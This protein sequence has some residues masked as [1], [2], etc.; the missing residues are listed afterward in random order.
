MFNSINSLDFKTIP[1]G[2]F[3]IPTAPQK[4]KTIEFFDD[5]YTYPP[6]FRVKWD[7]IDELHEDLFMSYNYRILNKNFPFFKKTCFAE[8]EAVKGNKNQY[9]LGSYLDGY[10]AKITSTRFYSQKSKGLQAA[11]QAVPVYTILNG[12]GEIVLANSTDKL[13]SQSPDLQSSLYQFCGSFDPIIERDMQLGLFFLSRNDAEVYLQEIAKM[14][15]QGTKMLGLSIHCFG[16][17]FAYRV[18]REYHPQIDFR[19]IPNLQSVQSFLKPA[20][21]SNSNLIFDESQQQLRFR[22]RPRTVL[23]VFKQLN[24]WF[25]PISSFLAKSEYFKGVPIFV[26]QVNDNSTNFLT[27]QGSRMVN[28]V[29]TV[30]AWALKPLT[31]LGG[32]GNHTIMQGSIKS[33][34]NKS[35]I[36]TYVFFNHAE[37]LDFC[38]L[39]GRQIRHYNGSYLKLFDS[40]IKKP[41]IFVHNLEDFF[42]LCEDSLIPSTSSNV[43]GVPNLKLNMQTINFVSSTN[44]SRDVENYYTQPQ[45]SSLQKLSQFFNFKFRRLGGFIEVVLNTN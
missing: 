11:L 30:Y 24:N 1:T 25:S 2:S 32:F 31:T 43:V 13:K 42:E 37:A 34:L 18:M 27:Q 20:N 12:Q 8:E 6:K 5:L 41:T 23:P 22:R 26:V 35:S 21:I 29:D 10:R 40:V 3:R 38:K 44:S 14:D 17:D 33:Q 39:S 7:T 45:K 16:L 36:R 9:P 19:F 15:T 28:L 4:S